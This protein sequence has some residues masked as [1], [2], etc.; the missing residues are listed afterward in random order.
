LKSHL[1]LTSLSLNE[2]QIKILKIV[3]RELSED[4]S[5]TL[6]HII[7]VFKIAMSIVKTESDVDIE[8][9]KTAILLHDI[10]RL[11]EDKDNSGKTDHSI[12]GAEMAETILTKLNYP[13]EKIEKI[14]NCISSHRYRSNISPQS[15]EARILFDAD[16]ID[17]LGAIGIARL[18]MIAGK[19]NQKPYSSKPIDVYIRENLINGKVNGRIKEKSKHSPNIEFQTKI[20]NIPNKLH[21]LKA[22]E[23]A[24]ERIAFMERFFH[25]LK[26]DISLD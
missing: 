16:K 17:L 9:L 20:V 26:D 21:T 10:A 7:R 3:E 15:K 19:Y 14:K 6:E 5:H 8:V 11:I 22:K 25:Q 1:N 4:P 2:K 24:K 18:Y 23:M 13:V 12:L